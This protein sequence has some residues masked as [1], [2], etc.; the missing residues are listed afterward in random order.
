[1]APTPF[2]QPTY[3]LSEKAMRTFSNFE[4]A[5]V[6]LENEFRYRAH[7][8]HSEKWQGVE[9]SN[10]PDMAMYEIMHETFSVPLRGFEDLE[11]WREDIKPNLP[12]A[13]MHFEERVSGEPS[14][15]GE[16]WKIWPWGN[17]ADKHRTEGGK[18]TH[19]YQERFWPKYAGENGIGEN[20]KNWGIRY[21]YGDLNDVVELLRREPLTRQAYLPIWFPEDTGASHG[22]RLPC[23]LGYHFLMRHEYL[24]V[25]YSIRSC[26]FI[27]HFRDD[28]Y[29]TV[30]LLLWI[31]DRLRIVDPRWTTVRPGL[32]KM[33]IGSL[34]MFINDWDKIFKDDRSQ[35]PHR[36]K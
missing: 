34:H 25:E 26:D 12:F 18:F 36:Y 29:L 24:H 6:Q 32:F 31:L 14:N 5:A 8:V 27:R 30:R 33:N 35:N 10:K 4:R 9:I 23:S 13:D 11:H 19:T 15:P 7:K 2:P 21:P 1:M 16:A 20:R 28:C 3:L 17:A 22:G